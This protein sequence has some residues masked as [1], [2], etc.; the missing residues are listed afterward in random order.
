LGDVNYQLEAWVVL[1]PLV[2]LYCVLLAV[3]AAR[4]RPGWQGRQVPIRLVAGI[5]IAGVLYFTFFPLHVMYGIYANHAAWYE[6]VNW[7][8]IITIDPSFVPN[9]VMTIPLGILLPLM[10]SRVFSLRR[11]AA[12][13]A[14]FSA[15]IECCQ[16][17]LVLLI[18]NDRGMDVN[19]VI[20]N[21]LGGMI[22]YAIIRFAGP[23]KQPLRRFS[24]PDSVLA[25][26]WTR[27][28]ASVATGVRSAG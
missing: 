5:Y 19:D 10:S 15:G 20:A 23:L 25:T 18:N 11:A 3:R 8:A 17:L 7:A 21:T 6:Q 14:I 26:V 27:R 16:L 1:G 22:G 24:L 12:W 28:Q 13:A 2:V 9:A 4:K